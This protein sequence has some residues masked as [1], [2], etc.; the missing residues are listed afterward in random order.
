VRGVVAAA[1]PPAARAGAEVLAAGGSALDAA[2]AAALVMGV[3]EPIDCG[4]AAG[5]FLVHF[6]AGR[7]VADALD[8]I[9]AAP[10][11]VRYEFEPEFGGF[12][13]DFRIRVRDRA[14]EIGARAVAVPG[15]LR[16]FEAAHRRFGRLPWRDLVA[17]AARV[18]R[19]GFSCDRYFA[20]RVEENRDY[21]AHFP[22]SR[23]LLMP[24][25]APPPPGARLANPDLAASLEAVAREG[26]D[27]LYGGSLAGPLLD[28][29]GRGG[30]FIT[31][32]DLR[33][34]RAHWRR[35]AEGQVLGHTVWSMPAPSVGPLVLASLRALSAQLNP[36]RLQA[37]EAEAVDLVLRVLRAAA[38]ERTTRLADP[39]FEP[40]PEGRWAEEGFA[41]TLLPEGP[42]TTSLS[43]IDREGNA[44]SLT[45]SNMNFA[46][47]TV[48]GTG[49]VLNNQ[50]LLFNPL[51]GAANSVAPGKRPASSMAPTVA[52]KAGRARLALGASGGPR[53]PT[54][55]V[56]VALNRLVA[57]LPIDAAVRQWR[58]HFE[59]GVVD[60][61]R[62]LHARVGA[63]LEAHGWT[64][65]PMDDHHRMLA[66][67]QAVAADDD[68]RASGA[69]DPRGD[70]AAA[71]EDGTHG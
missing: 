46:G 40:V 2:V 37:Q 66:L 67:C 4:L 48:A 43:V 70:G 59:A 51:P 42:E 33:A 16:G 54:A 6:D 50:M 11:A 8:F 30:G 22:E 41:G 14:N 36:G 58:A 56:W 25:G 60:V 18:A 49:I 29:I 9:G 12:L 39:L 68:G 57:G 7:G 31:A 21:L 71:A 17:P 38:A 52:V 55:V 15:A 61:E 20:A 23:R 45:Y 34:Y 26:P 53:I 69:G 5:G 44:C 28:E 35:P 19:E 63:A 1:S 27:A 3:V 65:N 10:Q 13:K 62:S 64:L 47:I 32:A 24:G